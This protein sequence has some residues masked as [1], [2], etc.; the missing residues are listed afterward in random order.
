[1]DDTEL[2]KEL[3]ARAKMTPA[4]AKAVLDVL[5]EI[6]AEHAVSDG[7]GPLSALDPRRRGRTEIHSTDPLFYRPTPS[8]VEALIEFARQHPLGIDFLLEGEPG[9]VAA[10]FRTHA[11]T[12]DAARRRLSEAPR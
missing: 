9:C 2:V 10:T 1:M 5:E 11:F 3:A 12:V 4:A 6:A 8:E 7:P